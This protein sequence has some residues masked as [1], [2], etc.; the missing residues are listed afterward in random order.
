MNCSPASA[1]LADFNVLP[2]SCWQ[3]LAEACAVKIFP[4]RSIDGPC[5]QDAGS[6]LASDY[7]SSWS[8]GFTPFTYPSKPYIVGLNSPTMLTSA[9]AGTLRPTKE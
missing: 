9:L 3:G 1:T 4:Y 2:A 8:E 7:F 6:T 5:R